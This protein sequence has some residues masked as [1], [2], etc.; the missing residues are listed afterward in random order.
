MGQR[1]TRV[2]VT[3]ATGLIG[4][5]VLAVGIWALLGPYSFADYMGFPVHVHFSHDA[6]AF[7]IGIGAGL[8]L[9]LIWADA[10]ATV[11]AG[12]LLANT[13]HVVNHI[14]D[15]HLGG[16]AYQT[17]LLVV[18]S[19]LAAIALV[20]RLR[21]R[22]YVVGPVAPATVSALAP[23]VGQKTV[24]LTTF[25]RDGRPGS[26]PVSIVVDG[27]HAY[28][29][30]FETSL[31]TRRLRRDR[32]V[33]VAPSTG[34][35]VPTGPAVAGKMRLLDGAENRRAARA[36]RRKHPLLHGV[37]VPLAHRLGRSKSGRTVHFELTP[38]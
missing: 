14:V 16:N 7:Q 25:R 24:T 6:G 13:I 30:S 28:V 27:D 15:S 31:K 23:F 10:L 11:L 4:V 33:E 1:G 21:A 22:G 36:L 17:W 19:V 12:F 9:A 26:S 32:R 37:V 20:L 2:F 18:Q 8:L 3:A 29:R 38:M 5:S 35:G 34:R